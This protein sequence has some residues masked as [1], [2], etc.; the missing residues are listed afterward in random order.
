M[1]HQQR[2][3]TINIKKN[4]PN[5]LKEGNLEINPAITEE[6]KV[7]HSTN[8]F[9]VKSMIDTWEKKPTKTERKKY[10]VGSNMFDIAAIK[11]EMVSN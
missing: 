5:T 4:I 3:Y 10:S 2:K 9:Q 8:F 7:K 1:G 11:I 6:L